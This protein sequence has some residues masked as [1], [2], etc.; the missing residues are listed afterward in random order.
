GQDH[1]LAVVADHLD[2]ILR[3][4]G[5]RRP[6]A[7]IPNKRSDE[8]EDKDQR[9]HHVVMEGAARMSPVE[10]ALQD[11]AEA[12]PGLPNGSASAGGFHQGLPAYC[13]DAAH[14]RAQNFGDKNCAVRLLIIFD[15]GDPSAADR[16]A[17][18]VKGVDELRFGLGALRGRPVADIRTPGLKGVEIRAGGNFAVKTLPWQPDLQIVGLGGREAGVAGAE[19]DAPIGQFELFEDLFGVASELLVL[20]GGIFGARELDQLDLLELVLADDAAGVL[21]GGAGLGAEARRICRKRDRQAGVVEDFVAIEIRDRNF[22]GG[23]EPVIAVLEF[24]PAG[25]FGVSVGTAEKI[26]GALGQLS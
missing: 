24:A 20:L 17:A 11:A 15:H 12:V 14:V 9:H 5:P 1:A 25:G 22:G 13:I 10:I 19:Q 2:G 21:A 4:A 26:L 18:S 16:E 23:N 6:G 8:D 7:V 3:A